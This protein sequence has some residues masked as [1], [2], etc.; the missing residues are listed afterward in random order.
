MTDRDRFE[1]AWQAQ[2]RDLYDSFKE[3]AWEFWL[4][5]RRAA[6]EEATAACTL[7]LINEGKTAVGLGAYVC[8]RAIRALPTGEKT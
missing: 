2:G 6:L 5:G 7:T 3:G 4:A 8:E 1:A